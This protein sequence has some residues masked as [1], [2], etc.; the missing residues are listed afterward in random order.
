MFDNSSKVLLQIPTPTTLPS[1][2]PI[3]I[4]PPFVFE[5]AEMVTKYHLNLMVNF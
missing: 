5:N 1:S 4:V 2:T 3:S